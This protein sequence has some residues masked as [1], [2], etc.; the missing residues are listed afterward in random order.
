MRYNGRK[1][2]ES[3]PEKFRPL[4]NRINIIL[5]TTLNKYM[6]IND[7]NIHTY[8]VNSIEQLDILLEQLT[9]TGRLAKS[10]VIG[11][12][13]IYNKMFELNDK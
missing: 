13:S 10:F 8:I 2:W 12:A 3:I 5:S 1:T 9:E 6:E 4:P 11:G 7:K